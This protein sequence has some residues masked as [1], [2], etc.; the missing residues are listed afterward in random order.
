MPD[1]PGLAQDPEGDGV[2]AAL[3]EEVAAEAEHVGPAPQP[4]PLG[5]ARPRIQHGFDEPLGVGAVRVGVDVDGVAGEP[6]GGVAG[7]FG[8]FGGVLGQVAGDHA[9][10]DGAVGAEVDGADVELGA[11][12]DEPSRHGMSGW[13][14]GDV[15]VVVVAA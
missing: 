4:V 13:G 11:P 15:N 5:S 2:V 9:V 3:G 7:R 14:R 8:G 12:R 6:A 10:G 1:G